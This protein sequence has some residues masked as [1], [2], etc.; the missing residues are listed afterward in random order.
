[1]H[2]VG[3]EGDVNLWLVGAQT[4]A[5]H[6][7][8][9]QVGEEVAKGGGWGAVGRGGGK[10]G[11]ERDACRGAWVEHL[12]SIFW[13]VRRY[14]MQSGTDQEMGKLLVWVSHVRKKEKEESYSQLLAG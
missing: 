9:M 2:N 5:E 14:A 13:R 7:L 12:C 10:T 3:R 4:E 6:G 1:M 11:G 8:G